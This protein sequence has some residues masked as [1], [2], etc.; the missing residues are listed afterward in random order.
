MKARRRARVLVVDDEPAI[1]R[2]LARALGTTHDVEAVTSP[3]VAIERVLAGEHFD[4][5][6]CDLMMPERSGIEVHAAIER[7]SP[8]RAARMIF[9]TGGALTPKAEA[10][11]SRRMVVRKP[12]SIDE[13]LR[14][15]D[16]ALATLEK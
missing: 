11:L 7:F 3:D 2:M 12:F 4:L 5:I 10:F 16:G 13:L 6:L 8:E 1:V 14:R 15:I 9:L